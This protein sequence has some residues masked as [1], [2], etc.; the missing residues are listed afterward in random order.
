MSLLGKGSQIPLA[1]DSDM[2]I[3]Y[4][5]ILISTFVAV[6]VLVDLDVHTSAAERYE[7]AFNNVSSKV[8]TDPIPDPIIGPW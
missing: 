2:N 8:S 6:L 3:R 5:Q 4:D 7:S 1:T